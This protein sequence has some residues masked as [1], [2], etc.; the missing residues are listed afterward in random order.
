M[1]PATH[2]WR[3]RV[4]SRERIAIAVLTALPWASACQSDQMVCPNWFP[5][6]IIVEVREALTGAPA[7]VGASGE[8]R[9]GSFASPLALQGPNE[10]LELYSSGPAATYVVVVR[11]PGYHDWT[12]SGV[13]VQ[14]NSCGVMRSIVLRANLER[15]P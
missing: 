14:G 8:I 3:Y 5:S 13:Y 6:P 10:A 1:T 4:R 11:K 12:R 7:A 2:F 15:A 9:S